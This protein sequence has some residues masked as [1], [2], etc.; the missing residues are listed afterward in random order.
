MMNIPWRLC[1][2]LRHRIPSRRFNPFADNAGRVR[3]LAVT[4]VRDEIRFLP[5]LLRNIAPQVD[6]IIALDDGSSDGSGRL[7]EECPQVLELLRQFPRPPRLGPAGQPPAPGR[8]RAAP[9][10]RMDH[11]RGRR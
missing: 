2:S 10:R 3:L 9:W 5:G 8:G 1:L 4:M 6:G 11:R 7:L